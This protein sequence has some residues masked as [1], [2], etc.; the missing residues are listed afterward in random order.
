MLARLLVLSAVFTVATVVCYYRTW[1]AEGCAMVKEKIALASDFAVTQG[2]F[3]LGSGAHTY[4][5][6][7]RSLRANTLAPTAPP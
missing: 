3:R 4:P 6:T 1:M 7:Y 5:R 2:L